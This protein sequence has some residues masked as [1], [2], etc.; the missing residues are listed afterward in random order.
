MAAKGSRTFLV[1]ASNVGGEGWNW[2]KIQGD[3]IA[4]VQ[5]ELRT[6]ESVAVVQVKEG[7]HLKTV[8]RIHGPRIA[9]I[10]DEQHLKDAPPSP[11]R[12]TH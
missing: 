10:E 9:W 8:A 6:D 7:E 3:E 11:G 4:V 5:N 1:G 2:W 12:A